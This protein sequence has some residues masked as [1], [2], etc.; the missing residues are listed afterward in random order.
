MRKEIINGYRNVIDQRYRYQNLRDHF[1][2]PDSIQEH[3]V[4]QIRNY[5]LYY[6]YPEFEKRQEIDKAFQTL[7]SYIKQPQK[8]VRILLGS[9]VLSLRYGRHL[10]KLL[11]TGLN[12]FKSFKATTKFEAQLMENA[13]H[14]DLKPPFDENKIQNLIRKLPR[15]QIDHYIDGSQKLFGTLHDQ[16]LMKKI[17]EILQFIVNHMKKRPRRYAEDEVKGIQMGLDILME[18]DRIFNRL[19]AEDQGILLPYI[20]KVERQGMNNIFGERV[21]SE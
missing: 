21:N 13:L 3:T 7:N 2:L 12:A 11:K 15:Q 1:D 9:I 18:G 10:P 17:I 14:H 8:L 20:V 5:F 6:I 16:K 19:S 4:D